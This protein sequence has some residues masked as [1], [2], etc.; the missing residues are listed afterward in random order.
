[1]NDIAGK[2]GRRPGGWRYGL[3]AS[4]AVVIIAFIPQLSFWAERGGEWNGS[5]ANTHGDEAVYS[6]YVNALIDGRP[7]RNDPYT[8]RD[9]ASDAPQSE[10]YFSIQFI[11]PYAVAGLAR[12]F[13]ATTAQAFIALTLV[14]AI[15]ASLAVFSLLGL[16]TGDA[17]TAATGV[18]IVLLLGSSHILAQHL[19][20]IGTQ[21]NFLPFLRRY[22]PSVP[23]PLFFVFCACVWRMLIAGKN[24]TALLWALAASASFAILVYSYFYLWTSAA[25]WLF[26]LAVVW[27]F[28]RPEARRM[29]LKLFTTVSLLGV[30]SLA[31]YF[32]LLTKRAPSTDEGLLLTYSHAPDI[33]RLPELIGG[34]VL[35]AT[36]IAARRGVV[37]LGDASTVFTIS[38]AL[39]PFVVFNQQVVT[40]RSLQ[41]FH[42]GMFVVNYVAVL[43]A[44]LCAVIISRGAR[45][46]ASIISKIIPYALVLVALCSGTMEA[47]LSSKRFFL[48]NV[49]RDSARPAALRLAELARHDD[50]R[51]LDLSSLVLATDHTL[52]DALPGAAPQPVLWAPH[53][54]NFPGVTLE[55]D[56]DRLSHFLYLTGVELSEIDAARFEG[57]DGGRKYFVSALIGR[58][59][60]NPNLTVAWEPI[61]SDEV[62]GA[63]EKH[64]RYVAAFDR[65][66]A[67]RYE[68]AYVLTPA[69]SA[70]NLTNLDR[71]YTR[72]GG[73]RFGSYI[74]YRVTL[75]P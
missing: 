72:D 2:G 1:M 53:M 69:Q 3:L 25:A 71:W 7:R 67:A 57:L 61:T 6:A 32:Y 39:T 66:R 13:G 35:I 27:L 26:C 41:P 52:A 60:H 20:G 16:L 55:E 30:A 75:R 54:F 73:E 44:F 11:P 62:R 64:A 29:S 50:R 43:A 9:D 49:L 24:R 48:S 17:K 37:K 59:R 70:S 38:F 12:L 19:L 40:G 31:P 4:A 34:A 28:A 51:K 10:S 14:S 42:Y 56:A 74:L 58:S 63:L 5:A 46:Q 21:N 47:V 8:G 18:V 36:I 23:F 22:Q 45:F 15:A 33:F 68:L 65:K